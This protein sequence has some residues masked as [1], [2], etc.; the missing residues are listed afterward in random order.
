MARHRSGR[1]EK[2]SLIGQF[3]DAIALLVGGRLTATGPPR[4]LT[5]AMIERHYDATVQLVPD[6]SGAV[7]IVPV[8]RR[9][10]ARAAVMAAARED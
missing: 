7:L 10:H 3:A 1:A 4:E 2:G 8:R 9:D 5:A 6:G